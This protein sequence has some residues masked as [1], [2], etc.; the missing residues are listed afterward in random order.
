MTLI[1]LDP[2][3]IPAG[4][5]PSYDPDVQTMLDARA[6]LSDPTDAAYAQAISDW[7]T[8]MKAVPGW[9]SSAIQ[10]WTCAGA[11][12]VDSAALSI[13]GNNMNARFLVDADIFAKTGTQGNAVNKAWDTGYS[14]APSGTSG[15]NFHT[16][17]Y[18]SSVG[19]GTNILYG[20]GNTAGG[21]WNQRQNGSTRCFSSAADGNGSP[22]GPGGYGMNRSASAGYQRMVAN[23][24]GSVSRNSQGPNSG[25]HTLLAGNYNNAP[26]N[27]RILVYVMGASIST[28]DAY[29]TPTEDFITAL[30]AI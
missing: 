15:T 30:N 4:G 29:I 23:A 10:V 18:F 2:F 26:S 19:T 9:L 20:S 24:V 25:R 5:A 21:T 6:A 8:E 1:V 7:I 17:A 14:G 11:T 16:Y 27:A 12:T 22:V 3:R 13:K 28:L